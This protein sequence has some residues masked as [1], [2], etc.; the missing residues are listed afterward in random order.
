MSA[1]RHNPFRLA[2]DRAGAEQATR[3]IAGAIRTGSWPTVVEKVRRWAYLGASERESY[4]AIYN[5]FASESGGTA[6]VVSN[7]SRKR[8]PPVAGALPADHPLIAAA[9][10]LYAWAKE[11]FGNRAV[12]DVLVWSPRPD[13]LKVAFYG[14]ARS[15]LG[16]FGFADGSLNNR[17]RW[18][19]R[20]FARAF[21]VPLD[22]RW[23]TNRS[24]GEQVAIIDPDLSHEDDEVGPG[25]ILQAVQNM[26][27]DEIPGLDDP[28][29]VLD[30][31]LLPDVG[32]PWYGAGT[33]YYS[34]REGRWI[35]GEKPPWE[36]TVTARDPDTSRD[37]ARP[38]ADWCALAS[39]VE[40]VYERSPGFAMAGA[41]VVMVTHAF[42]MREG[43]DHDQTHRDIAS[44]GGLLFPSV[45]VG[46]IPAANF[47]PAVLVADPMTVVGGLKPYRQRG[48]PL[49]APL[50]TTD[51]YTQTT[52]EFRGE[53][54]A[55]L[56]DELTGATDEQLFMLGGRPH[57]YTLGPPVEHEDD[58]PEGK[59]L[60]QTTSQMLTALRR[61][62]KLWSG[63]MDAKAFARV[64]AK[65]QREDL[66]RDANEFAYLEGK[67]HAVMPMTS[68]VAA[69]V[70]DFGLDAYSAFLRG[71]GFTGPIHV[72]A[73]SEA[74]RHSYLRTAGVDADG[75]P[76]YN[77]AWRVAEQVRAK[78]RGIEIS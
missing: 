30:V 8:P 2:T 4:D 5:A 48:A 27:R 64:M 42:D 53:L 21:D 61:R 31:T 71:A 10:K 78:T 72:M 46:P 56:Y 11:A 74:E 24:T 59:R 45:A 36:V 22:V 49:L 51:A 7:P 39:R 16:R 29:I 23:G 54:S 33:V 73:T 12:R 52:R 9:P 76:R 43:R 60:I 19:D 75:L 70:P 28:S 3:E 6:G 62:F 38:G 69:W 1:G 37:V 14:D 18:L 68:F 17:N 58:G 57:L 77:Y 55:R 20:S 67:V 25:A 35:A 40:A 66:A 50:Y 15:M 47:G 63:P 65:V 13:R 32:A 34:G 26:I 44:C 41:S